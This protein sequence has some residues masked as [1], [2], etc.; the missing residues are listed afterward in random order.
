M[1]APAPTDIQLHQVSRQ[2]EIRFEDH[3]VFFLPFEFLRVFS[4]SAE[5][6]GHG[7]GPVVLPKGKQDVT[8]LKLRPVGHYGVSPIFSDGHQSGI[9]TFEYLYELGLSRDRLW[10]EYQ[11]QQPDALPANGIPPCKTSPGDCI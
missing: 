5:T 9:Y 1:M 3:Q 7:T 4:P 6:R 2:L 10:A 8:V 11:T